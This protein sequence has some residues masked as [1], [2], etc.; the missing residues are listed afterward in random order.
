MVKI[1]DTDI[2]HFYRELETKKFYMFG[3]GRRAVI[4]YEELELDGK[5]TAIIDNN[6]KQWPQGIHLGKNWIPVISV[7]HFLRQIDDVSKILLLITPSFYAG[8]IIKQLDQ[9]PELNNLRCYLGD[10]L[11]AQY[12]KKDFFF[13]NG[14]QK[15]PKKIHYCWFG[16]K[17]IPPH[18][19]KYID[20]WKEKCPEYEIISWD[21]SNYDVTK[22]RYMKEAYECGKWGFV[23]DYARLDLIYQEG[24]IYLDT[25]VE[26]VSSLD[27]LLCDDMFCIAENDISINFGSGFG[28]VKGHPVMKQLR[29]AYEEKTF[30]LEDGSMNM[31]PCYTYQNS[32]LKKI[33]FKIKNEYQKINGIVLYPSEVAICMKLELAQNHMTEN[34]IMK[35]HS[36]LSWIS[37]DEKKNLND[38]KNFIVQRKCFQ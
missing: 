14:K 32:I 24:G 28:A 4:F 5:I 25:D 2:P 17:N 3:A 29:D 38:Y 22:H 6:E 9:L 33:G 30:Y 31:M 34:T 21:E 20:T 7:E 15:I 23:S 1:I 16:K 36:E 11:I 27:R 12:E 37:E 13:S 10:L 35:H 26:L 8:E 19:C 18:L